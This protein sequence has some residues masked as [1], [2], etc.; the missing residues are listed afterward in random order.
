M[1][2]IKGQWEEAEVTNPNSREAFITNLTDG[3]V[4]E[5]RLR[6]RTRIGR[7]SDWTHFTH[8]VVGKTTRPHPVTDLLYEAP[9]VTWR[10]PNAPRDLAGYM[11]RYHAGIKTT[12][13]DATPFNDTPIQETAFNVTRLGRGV[14]TVLVKPVDIAGNEAIAATYISVNL[15][16]PV[17]GNVVVTEDYKADGWPGTIINGS[18][19]SGDLAASSTSGLWSGDN[20]KS[21]WSGNDNTAIWSTS[22]YGLRYQFEYVPGVDLEG[23]ALT[24]DENVTGSSYSVQYRT[25]PPVKFWPQDDTAPFWPADSE[26][27]WPALSAWRAWP[28]RI[29][30]I[31]H[32]LYQ[33]RITV[34]GGTTQGQ[35]TKLDLNVDVPDKEE[36]FGDVTLAAGG[37]RL[38]IT[39]SYRT[40]T[41]VSPTLVNDGGAAVTL[42]VMDKDATNGP[43]VQ[44]FDDTGAGTPAII[45]ATVQGY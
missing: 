44:A 27:L 22:Y 10:Y 42:K 31:G 12:W 34:L 11:V 43:L 39:K 9:Y 6:H 7:E 14:R 29:D 37:T 18:I 45:D 19:V 24:L 21:L 38:P 8:E 26:R 32:Q 35:I 40:I 36:S 23:E 25:T 13:A 2:Y 1:E 15:G 3:V 5:V 20:T 41:V 28:G 16:D 33:F 30:G 17:V 4:Y